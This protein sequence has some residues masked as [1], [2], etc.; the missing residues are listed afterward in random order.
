MLSMNTLKG[1]KKKP[2]IVH[3]MEGK[4]GQNRSDKLTS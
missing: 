3:F 1:G 4:L 2:G